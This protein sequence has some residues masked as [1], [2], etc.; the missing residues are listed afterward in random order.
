[1]GPFVKPGKYIAEV[2]LDN[3]YK[4]SVEFSVVG[5]PWVCVGCDAS[6]AGVPLGFK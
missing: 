5:A 3:V 1:M 4:I 6:G 2:T